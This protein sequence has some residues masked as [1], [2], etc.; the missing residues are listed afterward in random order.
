[1]LEKMMKV[2]FPR[3][4]SHGV[5][6]PHLSPGAK[7]AHRA[8]HGVI[9]MTQIALCLPTVEDDFCR[10]GTV[11]KITDHAFRHCKNGNPALEKERFSGGLDKLWNLR[12]RKS[13]KEISTA[14]LKQFWL[15]STIFV[16]FIELRVWTVGRLPFGSL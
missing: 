15:D 1:M 2:K 13:K 8:S 6:S 9:C 5:I 3:G 11:A 14:L 12:Q 16:G 4:T 10:Y 7:L